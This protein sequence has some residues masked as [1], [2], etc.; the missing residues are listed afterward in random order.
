M[1]FTWVAMYRYGLAVFAVTLFMFSG[2]APGI[3]SSAAQQ[4]PPQNQ[5]KK[6]PLHMTVILERVYLDGEISQEVVHE[7]CWSMENFWAKYDQWQMVDMDESTM[8]FR[9]QVDD[10][11]PLLKANGFFGITEDGVLTIFNGRPDRSK[12][13]QSFF[14]IDMKKLE[15]K[16]QEDLIQ[17]IPIK[18]KDH[19]V[20][21]L[22]TFKPYSIKK[23]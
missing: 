13:I 6:E 15:S 1:R 17:G 22:E 11:S 8:V 14:Q 9:R 4:E 23:E 21:V 3:T 16:T 7:T 2:W 12:I 10:I 19:Y 20:E 18:S 5:Q